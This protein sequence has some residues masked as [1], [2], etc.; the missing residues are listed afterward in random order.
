MSIPVSKDET[1]NVLRAE[2]AD[3]PDSQKKVDKLGAL[4]KQ[5]FVV[6]LSESEQAARTALRLAQ[7]LGYRDGEASAHVH[8]GGVLNRINL[9]DEGMQHFLSALSI[10]RELNDLIGIAGTINNIGMIQKTLGKIDETLRCFEEAQSLN[11]QTGNLPFLAI[12]YGNLGVIYLEDKNDPEQ[13]L[14]YF[15]KSKEIREQLSREKP[16]DIRNLSMD[17]ML[18]SNIGCAYIK[19][20][21]LDRADEF[22]QQAL[23]L[24]RD[25]ND[26]LGC[27]KSLMELAT[28]RHKQQKADESIAMLDESIE[29]AL[30][31]GVQELELHVCDRAISIFQEINNPARALEFAL[32]AKDINQ[33]IFNKD[34]SKSLAEQAARF[35]MERK[36]KDLEIERLKNVELK[37]AYD[38]LAAAQK[39]LIE[40]EKLATLGELAT[41]M[42]HEIQNPL[43]FVN[44]FS[45]INAELVRELHDSDSNSS[46]KTNLINDIEQN[47]LQILQH[48]KRVSE[49][50]KRLMNHAEQARRNS[51]ENKT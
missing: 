8:V 11:E 10:Y 32:R 29:L 39:Q 24:Q 4:A 6:N 50:V 26:Q 17:A 13:A 42:T 35:D 12:N 33:Q 1:L 46:D 18:L 20:N 51:T 41:E 7:Q 45:E 43:N 2:I 9:S 14:H 16:G 3:L 19:R 31:S 25:I 38:D 47:S 36:E 37:R 44:N 15:F 48:G 23:N 49:I 21:E 28:I 5:L 27:G 22:L 30:Q 40:K 34:R